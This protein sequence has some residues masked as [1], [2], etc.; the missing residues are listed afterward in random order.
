MPCWHLGLPL[1]GV[2]G[3]AAGLSL[4]RFAIAID[5]VLTMI[6]KLL[7][8]VPG[9]IV[10][11]CADDIGAVLRSASLLPSLYQA[12]SRIRLATGLAVKEK[13]ASLYLCIASAHWLSVSMERLAKLHGSWMACVQDCRFGKIYWH[14]SGS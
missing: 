9:S 6:A 7:E 10:R 3:C 2:V 11:T 12:Y 1:F 13:N 4:E 5:P 8:A 14:F